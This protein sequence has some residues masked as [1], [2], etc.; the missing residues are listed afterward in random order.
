MIRIRGWRLGLLA[1]GSLLVPLAVAP[2]GAA[3]KKGP[4]KGIVD[5]SAFRDLAAEDAE[6]V[7][8]NVG[9]A[10]LQALAGEKRAEGEL[11]G[12]LR[13]LQ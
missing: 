11:G 3:E 9:G 6:V 10:M 1:L 7:E 2:A 8:V 5:G 12:L 13:G 4:I